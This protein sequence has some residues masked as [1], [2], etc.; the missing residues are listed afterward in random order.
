MRAT[1]SNQQRVDFMDHPKVTLTLNP[2]TL[3]T[4]TMHLSALSAVKLSKELI[5]LL[6]A[7]R[8]HFTMLALSPA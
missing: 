1:R 6:G 2:P 5:V 3:N 8:E 7:A 4:I